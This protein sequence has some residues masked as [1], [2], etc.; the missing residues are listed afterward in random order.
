MFRGPV[1]VR[2]ML[3]QLALCKNRAARDAFLQ[4]V[5]ERELALQ[6]VVLRLK[7]SVH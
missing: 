1:H 2:K 7:V 5:V 4:L 6:H 3:A